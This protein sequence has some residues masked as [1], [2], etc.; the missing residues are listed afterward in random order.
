MATIRLVSFV[1]R[2]YSDWVCPDLRELEEAA[3]AEGHYFVARATHEWDSGVNRFDRPG[4]IFFLATRQNQT[5]GMCGLNRD[6]YVEDPAV[7]RLRHL[8]VLPDQRRSGIAAKLV[9][10]CLKSSSTI[11]ERVRLRTAN[12]GAAALYLSLGF[13]TIDDPTASHELRS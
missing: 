13:V 7:G 11:F 12:P 4:E 8:Y 10:E 2:A 9:A 5:V 3:A 1:L 6:P